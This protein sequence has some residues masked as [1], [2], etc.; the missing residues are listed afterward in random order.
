MLWGTHTIVINVKQ[1]LKCVNLFLNKR[2]ITT[3]SDVRIRIYI[4][5]FLQKTSNLKQHLQ[6]I[7]QNDQKWIFCIH[8]KRYFSC[9]LFSLFFVNW[10]LELHLCAKIPLYFVSVA[11]SRVWN[12]FGCAKQ[13]KYKH[14]T[15]FCFGWYWSH[16][17]ML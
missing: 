6:K 10:S 3:L 5:F 1:D 17:N 8:Y 13:K 7:S 11:F 9:K 15:H 16:Y 4:S 14:L 12:S 2:F